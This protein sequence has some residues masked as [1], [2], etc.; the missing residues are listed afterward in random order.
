MFQ[1]PCGVMVLQLA[2]QISGL[3]GNDGF[4]PLAGLWSCNPRANLV[5]ILPQ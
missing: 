1:S 4:S 2:D 3:G 5:T